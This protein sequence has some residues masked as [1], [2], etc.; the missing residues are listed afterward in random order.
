MSGSAPPSIQTYQPTTFRERGLSVGF[1]TPFLAGARVRAAVGTAGAGRPERSIE[2]VVPNPSGGRGVYVVE[3]ERVSE[4]CKPT[5]HDTRLGAALETHHRLHGEMVPC[6]IRR[7]TRNVVR[8]GLAGRDAA[9]SAK[10]AAAV[11]ENHVADTHRR[12]MR[13]LVEADGGGAGADDAGLAARARRAMAPMALESGRD[14]DDLTAG[15]ERLAHL[16]A[17]LGTDAPE[18]GGFV[19]QG[20]AALSQL[21]SNLGRRANP[22]G[23]TDGR[24]AAFVVTN[25]E[26]TT[27]LVR[28]AAQTARARVWAM[29]RSLAD[30]MQ[31]PAPF[32]EA[33]ARPEWLLDGW[34]R[35]CLLWDAAP[36]GTPPCVTI[37]EMAALVPP[38]P[39]QADDW[40]GL[41]PGTATKA[42]PTQRGAH[43][44]LAQEGRGMD[45]VARNER[46][47][48]MAA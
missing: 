14:V 16:A 15:L 34:T 45:I 19:P 6:E 32:V 8:E 4:M 27:T 46:L 5:L 3:W 48:A 7:L 33:A 13:A 10:A 9:A 43:G 29:P 23:G 47:L 31:R 44:A 1:T 17:D 20:L 12:L 36:D 2:L 39:P 42:N 37:G 41:P 25:A 26:L 38:I 30:W 40:L 21:I 22:Q 11:A 35:I 18:A 28:R 24:S